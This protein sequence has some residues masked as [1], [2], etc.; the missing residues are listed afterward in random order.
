[1]FARR[2]YDHW[3]PRSTARPP[4]RVRPSGGDP[5]ATGGP[6]PRGL[7]IERI[8]AAAPAIL[9][10]D[11]PRELIMRRLAEEL[12][13]GPASIYRHVAGREELLVEMVDQVRGERP[14][15]GGLNGRMRASSPRRGPRGGFD[16]RSLWLT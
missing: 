1:M 6:T 11:G 3:L 4:S 9:D 7:V 16:C 15:A 14:S 10:R 5:V 2:S 13:T 12:G 8:C